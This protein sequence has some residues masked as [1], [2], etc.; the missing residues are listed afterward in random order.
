MNRL[1]CISFLSCAKKKLC[2]HRNWK[3]LLFQI[4][5]WFGIY[6]QCSPQEENYSWQDLFNI[7]RVVNE[8]GNLNL[9]GDEL[10]LVAFEEDPRCI[11]IPWYH[12]CHQHYKD[13]LHYH[14]DYKL[15]M[16]FP[17]FRIFHWDFDCAPVVWKDVLVPLSLDCQ[18]RPSTSSSG[19][20]S[21][22]WYPDH[23]GVILWI[24]QGSCEFWDYMIS[25]ILFDNQ[26]RE[27]FKN[28][29]HG[30]CPLGGYP[31]PA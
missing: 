13:H 19:V 6:I 28:P 27:G 7:M 15:V 4:W 16:I 9:A 3:L 8:G 31:P 17:R 14:H 25:R 26:V 18:F 11:D 2:K 5:F 29:S 1:S 30:I 24:L 23:Y 10:L 20:F 21:I 22:S 12:H